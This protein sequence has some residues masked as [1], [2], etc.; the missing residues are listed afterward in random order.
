MKKIIII[1]G[2]GTPVVIAEQILNAVEKF[3]EKYELLGFAFDDESFGDEINGIPI[4]DKTYNVYGKYKRFD[5]VFFIYSLY[6]SDV[7]EERIKLRESFQIPIQR[8]LTFIH[9]LATVARSAQIGYGNIILANVVI[10]PNVKMGNFNT[11]NSN[12]LVGHDTMMGDNNFIAGHSVIGSNLKIGNGNFFG[13]NSSSK[14]FIN[15]DDY[16]IIGM[17]ANL[18]KDVQSKQI[19]IGNPAKPLSR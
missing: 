3:G 4:L 14:N 7:I 16:N 8:Y 18:V 2:K 9:P 19:L 12:S 11:F 1:G 5:D 17:A 10:N 13:L 6:R 15:I